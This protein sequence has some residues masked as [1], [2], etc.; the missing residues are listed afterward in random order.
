MLE[1]VAEAGTLGLVL[2]AAHA[3]ARWLPAVLGVLALASSVA[4]TVPASPC[5]PREP[6]CLAQD[7]ATPG[8][9]G[10]ELDLSSESSE[11]RD[12]DERDEE[13]PTD[14]DEVALDQSAW[15]PRRVRA[16]AAARAPTG[17]GRVEGTD[18]AAHRGTPE[19][20]P[21]A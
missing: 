6:A 12:D 18:R 13:D 11:G 8:T 16:G 19:R 17:E 9:L 15:P 2:R 4:T 14:S 5:D 21:H 3:L 7:R 20:P 1:A 10:V